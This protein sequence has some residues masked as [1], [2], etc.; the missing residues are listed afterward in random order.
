L[1]GSRCLHDVEWR[2]WAHFRFAK[3]CVQ[4]GLTTYI[5]G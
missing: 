5:I 2:S 3:L 4:I 1:G